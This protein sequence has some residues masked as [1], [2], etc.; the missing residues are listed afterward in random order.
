MTLPTTCP[1]LSLPPEIASQIFLHC[2]PP[3]HSRWYSPQNAPWLLLQ[4]SRQWRALALDTHVLWTSIH[5]TGMEP[6]EVLETWLARAGNLPL[7][8]SLVDSDPERAESLLN[9]SMRYCHQW[10]DV[11]LQLPQQLDMLGRVFPA[12]RKLSLAG[13]RD[14]SGE[15]IIIRDAPLLRE[16]RLITHL[17]VELPWEQLTTL[18]LLPS[19]L[20]QG[21]TILKRCSKLVHLTYTWRGGGGVRGASDTAYAAN[22]PA[23]TLP[24]LQTLNS[25]SVPESLEPLIARSSCTLQRLSVWVLGEIDY[26]SWR[27]FEAVVDL[28]LN[29]LP[30]FL[31]TDV[32]PQLRNLR[33]CDATDRDDWEPILDLLRS[34][35][36]TVLSRAT[37]ESFEL[38][39]LTHSGLISQRRELSRRFLDDSTM[40]QFRSLAEAGLK[41]RIDNGTPEGSLEPSIIFDSFTEEQQYRN[42]RL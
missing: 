23:L 13:R 3:S 36:K 38:S 30:P 24:F 34:R 9:V 21:F 29:T 4:V 28:E 6:I 32:L 16:V 35:R 33:I 26:L 10:Q 17:N 39:L 41:V 37:L 1:V 25:S 8:L 11:R 20:E 19:T 15:A 5:M 12:L 42:P 22:L 18:E 31:P 27:C 14:A 7:T 2:L 40:S